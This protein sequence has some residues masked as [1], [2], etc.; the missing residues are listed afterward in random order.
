MKKKKNHNHTLEKIKLILPIILGTLFIDQLTK[1]FVLYTLAKD[2]VV[3]VFSFFNFVLVFNTGVSFGMFQ[4]NG[5]LGFWIL[6][7]IALSLCTWLC[8]I[9][10]QSSDPLEHISYSLVIGGAL[11]NVLDRFLY[12]GVVD[13]LQFHI[14][15]HYWPSFN[16]ADSAIVVGVALVLGTQTWHSLKKSTKKTT[17]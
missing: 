11:G 4:S 9:I 14:K 5:M 10:S 12:G 15:K 7:L 2:Q 16:I 6:I 17:R 3:H 8:Y 13:F 1:I